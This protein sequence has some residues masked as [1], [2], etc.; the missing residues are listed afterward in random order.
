MNGARV[1]RKHL[2][3][4]LAEDRVDRGGVRDRVAEVGAGQ[5]RVR[6]L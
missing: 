3:I 4:K 6:A 1:A 5:K 2:H